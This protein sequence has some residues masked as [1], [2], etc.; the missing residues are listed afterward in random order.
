MD[1]NS[2]QKNTA[3][4]LFRMLTV[5]NKAHASCWA[6]ILFLI[7]H[8]C[9]SSYFAPGCF[10]TTRRTVFLSYKTRFL[11]FFVQSNLRSLCNYFR[12][13][14]SWDF[15]FRHFSYGVLIYSYK[16]LGT[17]NCVMVHDRRKRR[18]K[19]SQSHAHEQKKQNTVERNR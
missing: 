14:V 7:S 8:F 19:L 11:C 9:L 6:I 5:W 17:G 2:K 1:D 4:K 3:I 13:G 10:I 12:G 16:K 18:N 15:L